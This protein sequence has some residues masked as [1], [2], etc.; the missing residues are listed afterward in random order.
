MK[1]YPVKRPQCGCEADKTAVTT[2]IHNVPRG[3]P[4]RLK[5]AQKV[6]HYRKR[7]EAH[8]WHWSDTEVVRI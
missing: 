5:S 8:F 2:V 6:F 1:L 4:P 3:Q 7:D